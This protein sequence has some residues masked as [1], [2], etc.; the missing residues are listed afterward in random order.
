MTDWDIVL[1]KAYA[2]AT[3]A[4]AAWEREGNHWFPCGFAWVTVPGRSA[5]ARHCRERLKQVT[6]HQHPYGDKAERGWSWWCPG[7]G[8]SQSM[9]KARRCAEAF[10]AVLKQHGVE[11]TT[12][13]RAD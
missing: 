8:A 9:V 2:A 12:G 1:G 7:Q 3:Q 13:S 11:A 5:L 6:G 10:A 4:G